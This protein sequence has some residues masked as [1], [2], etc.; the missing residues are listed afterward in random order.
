MIAEI[1]WVQE[2]CVSTFC[3]VA[4]EQEVW[5]AV[6][7]EMDK[8]TACGETFTVMIIIGEDL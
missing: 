4:N 6:K 8:A 5:E 7:V 2:E 3:E 1:V